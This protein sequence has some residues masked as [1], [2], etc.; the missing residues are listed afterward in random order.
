MDFRENARAEKRWLI[1]MPSEEIHPFM[2]GATPLRP[3]CSVRR[4]SSMEMQWPEGFDRDMLIVGRARDALTVDPASPPEALSEDHL[5][6]EVTPGKKL[7]TSIASTPAIDLASL[8]GD[9][10]VVGLR[11]RLQDILRDQAL[12]GRP[13]ALLLDDIV[14]CNI[15]SGWV[16][17]R[18]IADCAERIERLG[19][20][21][22]MENVC[23]AFKSGSQAMRDGNYIDKVDYV[24]PIQIGEDEHAF[25]ALSPDRDRTMRRL[26][27]VDVWREGEM[28]AVD[29]MFQDSAVLRGTRRAAVHQYRL[30]AMIDARTETLVSVTAV[31]IILPH[32][33]C[34]NAPATLEGLIGLP[35][36]ELRIRIL[37]QLRGPL[38][39]TH[40]NDAMRALAEVPVL[41]RLMPHGSRSNP[42][43]VAQ[44]INQSNS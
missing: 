12:T 8:V 23:I 5:R 11:R 30:Y 4:T 10:A 41:A 6:L 42:R 7:I 40:L 3:A 28:L 36:A 32:N 13:I 2:H 39:C 17:T 22:R 33:E 20:L 14:G 38:G 21:S 31:P 1:D 25:H 26:R 9:S 37:R 44:S 29:A 16:R 35:M 18:W 19:N 24:E 15:I 43:A 27:R 34:H